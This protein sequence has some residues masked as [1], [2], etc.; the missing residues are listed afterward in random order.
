MN[1]NN[2]CQ[3]FK[4]AIESLSSDRDFFQDKCELIEFLVDNLR[5]GKNEIVIKMEIVPWAEDLGLKV[6]Q[7]KENGHLRYVCSLE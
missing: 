4:R 6:R 1:T 2:P 3:V 7:K 5:D